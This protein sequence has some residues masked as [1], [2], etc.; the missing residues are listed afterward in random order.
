M[1]GQGKTHYG[2]YHNVRAA[3]Q[4][5]EK[6]RAEAENGDPSVAM[7]PSPRTPRT[8]VKKPKAKATSTNKKSGQDIHDTTDENTPTITSETEFDNMMKIEVD[9]VIKIDSDSDGDTIV[10]IKDENPFLE[11]GFAVAR[12]YLSKSS[13]VRNGECNVDV[14]HET[15]EDAEECADD[16]DAAPKWPVQSWFK[17]EDEA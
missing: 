2:I 7:K 9:D 10:K 16:L 6:L 15:F 8:R 11:E 5:A 1:F 13:S 3:R 4:M 14:R 12:A 17:D